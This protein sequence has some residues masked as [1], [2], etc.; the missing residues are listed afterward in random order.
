[1]REQLGA[2]AEPGFES[3]GFAGAYPEVF[4]SVKAQTTGDSRWINASI[5]SN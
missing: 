4:P 3:D 5:I 1:L 2:A